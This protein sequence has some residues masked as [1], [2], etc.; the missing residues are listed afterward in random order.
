MSD[1]LLLPSNFTLKIGNT[2][3]A[4]QMARGPGTI[5]TSKIGDN[6]IYDE[7][8]IGDGIRIGRGKACAL[9][10]LQEAQKHNV[11]VKGSLNIR[12]GKHAV[13]DVNGYYVLAQI[14]TSAN[15]LDYKNKLYAIIFIEDDGHVYQ[16]YVSNAMSNRGVIERWANANFN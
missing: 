2:E 6:F 5:V 13:D 11:A 4:G 16:D 9:D 7:N 8:D 3:I 14:R 10:F 12:H 1:H 15:I